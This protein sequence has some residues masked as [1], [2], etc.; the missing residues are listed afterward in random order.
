M[1]VA[2][3]YALMAAEDPE[4]FEVIDASRPIDEMVAAALA[5]LVTR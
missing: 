1:K 2:E 5:A 3:A 4:R